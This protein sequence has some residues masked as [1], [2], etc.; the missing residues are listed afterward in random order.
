MRLYAASV[1]EISTFGNRSTNSELSV[2]AIAAAVA[3]NAQPSRP[4]R[5]SAPAASTAT[6]ASTLSTVGDHAAKT[7]EATSVASQ[8][9]TPTARER[10]RTAPSVF[11]ARNAAPCSTDSDSSVSP[12][13][14]P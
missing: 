2:A 7:T 14:T 1:L 10:S 3:V 9:R 6:A 8:T 13:Q 11:S 5:S 12:V 4:A